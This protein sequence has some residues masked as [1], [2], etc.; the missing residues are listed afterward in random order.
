MAI[1][2]CN[3]RAMYNGAGVPYASVCIGDSRGRADANGYFGLLMTSG[4]IA[5]SWSINGRVGSVFVGAGGTA[6]FNTSPVNVG[7]I[8]LTVSNASF[9]NSSF[10]SA[11]SAAVGGNTA[12]VRIGTTGAHG[13]GGGSGA[14]S[15]VGG[16]TIPGAN[17]LQITNTSTGRIQ[18][19][20]A[21]AASPTATGQHLAAIDTW[22]G[23]TMSI[24]AKMFGY[25][26]GVLTEM[27]SG[28]YVLTKGTVL[29]LGDVS[30]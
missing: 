15:G 20:P 23:S 13:A 9:T 28:N 1:I 4:P 21:T 2:G 5:Q 18:L 30:V 3:G 19:A 6:V 8:T 11:T 22:S 16:A 25:I 29:N 27:L 17:Y 26:G 7:N 24:N 10:M 12:G 14:G